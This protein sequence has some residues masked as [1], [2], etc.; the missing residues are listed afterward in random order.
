MLRAVSAV[1]N[2]R[3]SD[4]AAVQQRE[5][6]GYY[7]LKVARRVSFGVVCPVVAT[8][9]YACPAKAARTL[10]AEDLAS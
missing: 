7:L 2:R 9:R 8:S 10:R 4:T 5:T 6:Q 3:A 1:V